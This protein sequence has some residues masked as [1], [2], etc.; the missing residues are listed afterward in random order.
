VSHSRRRAPEPSPAAGFAP[1]IEELRTFLAIA[2]DRSVQA[3]APR[4][5]RSRATAMRV[6]TDLER[7][8]GVAALL[9]RA[10]GQRS[11]VLT[12]EGVE[13]QRRARTIVQ[14]W[15]E[16]TI[17]TRDALARQHA[18]L[19]IGTLP[20][21][22]DLIAEPLSELRAAHPELALRVTEYTDER[23]LDAIRS[24][25]VDLGFGTVTPGQ[26]GAFARLTV[27]VLGELG[28]SVIVPRAMAARFGARVR[29]AQLDGVPMVVLREGPARERIEA[30]FAEAD[31]GPF[32][33]DAA[34]E[35]EATP[36]VVELVARGFGPAI[37]SRFRLAFLPAD[38]LVRDLE[39]GPPPL[40]AGVMHRRGARLS[41]AATRLLAL[42]RARF[43]ELSGA[44]RRR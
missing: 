44:R 36:R 3:A 13:L 39:G 21:S 35:V 14:Q 28:W 17:A 1:T 15:D 2:D 16:W 34:F 31:D 29:L 19:R 10:P 30:A 9:E 43:T 37:V 38:V 40:R 33:L 18:A 32:V 6:L 25:A 20:G 8:F 12:P 7:S 42:A 41:A 27:E 5:G 23:L 11:G 26:P 24:G 4:S 22:F